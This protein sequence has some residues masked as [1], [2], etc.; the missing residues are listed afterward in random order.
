MNSSKHSGNSRLELSE[1]RAW[2]PQSGH[3]DFPPNNETEGEREH[4]VKNITQGWVLCYYHSG[5]KHEQSAVLQKGLTFSIR[6]QIR[7]GNPCHPSLCSAPCCQTPSCFALGTL[8]GVCDSNHFNTMH[9]GYYCLFSNSVIDTEFWSKPDKLKPE[10]H[11]PISKSSKKSSRTDVRDQELKVGRV[12]TDGAH[13]SS[14]PCAFDQLQ[15]MTLTCCWE[16]AVSR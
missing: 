5:W 2:I 8:L 9:L 6:C 13:A 11:H 4:S 3:A 7:K 15:P 12:S 16:L 10:S 1:S 14:P